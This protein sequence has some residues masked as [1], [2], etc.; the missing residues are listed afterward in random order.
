MTRSLSTSALLL[1]MAGVF[2]AASVAALAGCSGPLSRRIDPDVDDSLGGTGI[3]SGDLRSVAQLMA[4]GIIGIPEIANA[5]NPPIVVLEPVRNASPF[6]IDAESFTMEIRAKLN[7]NCHRKVQFLARERL[8]AVLKER[9]AKRDG[10]FG[11]SGEK[12]LLGAD[13]IL[14]GQIRSL[15]KA[16]G[17]MR[18]D[19]IVYAFQLID[20]ESSLIVWEDSYNHKK[21]GKKGT[22]YR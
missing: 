6:V 9:K 16:R 4:E 18:S 1:F 3:D 13:F 8:E 21:E 14:T 19:Y 22:L 2:V 5:E 20:A 12:T 17:G 7:K 10:A 15:S 11:S